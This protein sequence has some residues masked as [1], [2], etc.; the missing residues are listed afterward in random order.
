MS[1]IILQN[2]PIKLLFME[3]KSILI[4]KDSYFKDYL[5]LKKHRLYVGFAIKR[6]FKASYFVVVCFLIN[7][8]NLK[9]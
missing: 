4:A 5:S 6:D 9:I 1:K 3:C 8:K 2:I 7:M